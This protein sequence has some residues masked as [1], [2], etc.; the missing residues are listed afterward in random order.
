MTKT[1]QFGGASK[2]DKSKVEVG[3]GGVTEAGWHSIADFMRCP[4]A[5]QLGVIRGIHVPVAQVP[6]HFARGLFF[7]AMRARW[8]GLEFASD[9]KAWT[10]IRDAAA[11]EAEKNKYPMAI[12]DERY[13]LQLMSLYMEHWLKR[14]LPKPVA[15]EYKIGPAP[16][17]QGDSFNMFRTAGL[18]DVSHY[19]EAGGALCIGES[20]TTSADIGA[21]VKEY[22]LHGQPMLQQALFRMCENGEKK[23]GPVKGTVLD[24]VVKPDEKMKGAK[25]ARIFVEIRPEALDWYVQSMRLWISSMNKVDWD[26]E[27]P[28][29]PHGCTYM[30]GRM[31]VDCAFKDLCRFGRS[32]A[33]RYVMRDGGSL[34]KWRPSLGKTRF[35]WE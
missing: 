24:V 16:L 15:A 4:K 27:T 21:V 34:T 2:A 18:D 19:P 12:S 3:K 11:E 6:A 25:F 17:A 13:A 32:A 20:K 26:A 28:R 23:F 7:H 5:Y 35:P 1:V 14:P 30:A 29:N 31:R 8:F 9:K 10:K 33:A 22:E